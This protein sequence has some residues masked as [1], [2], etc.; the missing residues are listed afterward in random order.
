MKSFGVV[1]TVLLATA[2]TVWGE[3]EKN[4]PAMVA[5]LYNI[6]ATM[7]DYTVEDLNRVYQ[8]QFDAEMSSLLPSVR[9]YWAQVTSYGEP[10]L[11]SVDLTD[12]G[13]VGII[14]I[15][16]DLPLDGVTEF[17]TAV[18]TYCGILYGEPHLAEPGEWMWKSHISASTIM[19]VHYYMSTY[20]PQSQSLQFLTYHLFNDRFN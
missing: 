1:L 6:A 16:V 3:T 14:F 5:E 2:G 8:Y 15:A 7:A 20:Q 4:Y 17:Y 13:K 19:F 12:T 18:K 11:F 9:S 10:L